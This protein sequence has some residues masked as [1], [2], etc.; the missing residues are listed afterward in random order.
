MSASSGSDT[1]GPAAAAHL[2]AQLRTAWLLRNHVLPRMHDRDVGPLA[3]ALPAA[4]AAPCCCPENATG[5]LTSS[6]YLLRELLRACVPQRLCPAT[7]ALFAR[8]RPLCWCAARALVPSTALL[9]AACAA[10][11]RCPAALAAAS[12]VVASPS[13]AFAALLRAACSTGSMDVLAV[14]DSAPFAPV[15]LDVDDG[16]LALA[17]ACCSG[18]IDV[19]R[20]LAQPPYSLRRVHARYDNLVALKRAVEQFCPDIVRE[21]AQPPWSLGNAARFPA[22]TDAL[23]IACMRNMGTVVEVLLRPPYNALQDYTSLDWSIALACC[24]YCM[25]SLEELWRFNCAMAETP[26]LDD[27]F[28]NHPEAMTPLSTLWGHFPEERDLFFEKYRITRPSKAVLQAEV[29]RL[30]RRRT[31]LL[32]DMIENDQAADLAHWHEQEV[33]RRASRSQ[34]EVS[35]REQEVTWRQIEKNRHDER[36]RSHE[37]A[38]LLVPLLSMSFRGLPGLL[39]PGSSVAAESAAIPKSE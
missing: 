24:Y 31:A 27:L 32:E 35:W 3:L 19:V 22:I 38:K 7:C 34:Q 25:R 8:W 14:L 39:A 11:S 26:D 18:N 6:D 12:A 4:L 13:L 28:A 37:L 15:A 5:H 10:L 29:G 17:Q 21:L 20:R 23:D 1:A 33:T 9:L 36:M 30:S 16:G 2:D